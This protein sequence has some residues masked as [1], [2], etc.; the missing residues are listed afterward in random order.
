[1]ALFFLIEIGNIKIKS[2]FLFLP[3]FNLL[4]IVD[5]G[6]VKMDGQFTRIIHK[7][8]ISHMYLLYNGFVKLQ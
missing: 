2:I 4:K 6:P 8:E 3:I 5:S 7:E 1:M